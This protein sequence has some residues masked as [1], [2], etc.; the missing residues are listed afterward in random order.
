LGLTRRGSAAALA[1]LL[2]SLGLPTGVPAHVD[3]AAAVRAMGADKKARAGAIRCA[4][5]ESPGAPAS[6]GGAWTVA[7]DRDV[8]LAAVRSSQGVLGDDRRF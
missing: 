4:L 8:L 7:V 6:A 2:A 3:A 1:R 5:I